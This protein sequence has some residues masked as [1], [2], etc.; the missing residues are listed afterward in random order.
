ME[1]YHYGTSF[2]TSIV[3]IT[4]DFEDDDLPVGQSVP[5]ELIVIIIGVN[6]STKFDPFNLLGS[7]STIG[8]RAT[9]NRPSLAPPK[10]LPHYFLSAHLF[11]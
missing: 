11:L 7:G 2:D 4:H 5:K 6:S 8:S 9:S 3:H 1:S 10:G